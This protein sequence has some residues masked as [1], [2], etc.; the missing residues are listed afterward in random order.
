MDMTWRDVGAFGLGAVAGAAV[1]E[2]CGGSGDDQ[3]I[4]MSGGSLHIFALGRKFIRGKDGHLIHATPAGNPTLRRIVDAVD[5]IAPISLG[6]P[7]IVENKLDVTVEY[8]MGDGQSEVLTLCSRARQ[9]LFVKGPN[10]AEYLQSN[11]AHIY[12]PE[13][14]IRSVTVNGWTHRMN[15]EYYL[16]V[17][18]YH[19]TDSLRVGVA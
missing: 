9:G 19:G 8:G 6:N 12:L 7:E 2:A 5:V 18:H 17:I 14:S 11:A 10:V 15:G 4:I 1:L 16:M 3:P 13:V